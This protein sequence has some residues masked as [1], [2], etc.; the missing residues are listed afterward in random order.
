MNNKEHNNDKY[1]R[2]Q[3]TFPF[4]SNK[5]HKSKSFKKV[6][7]KCY[8]EY[9]NFSDINDGMFCITNLDKN[10]EYRFKIKNKKIHK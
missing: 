9:K 2:Y 4:E 8:N 10:V 3:M 7:R 5:I 1:Y 6:V